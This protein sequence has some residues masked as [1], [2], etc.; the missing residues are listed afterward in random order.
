MTQDQRRI[1]AVALVP[2]FMSLLS[3]SIVNVVLPSIELSIGAGPSGLQWVLAGYTL[4]FGVMLVPAGR[5]GDLFGRARLFVLGVGLFGLAS[6]VAGLAPD[7]MVLN[8]ARL[9]MGFGSG[10]LN[11]QTVGFIQQ[12]FQGEQRGRAF[13]LF[14]SV[15]G[16]SVAIGPVLGGALIALL[17]PEWGWRSSFLINVPIAALAIGTAVRWLP[18]SAW[19][20]LPEAL[21]SGAHRKRPDLDP[22]GIVLLAAA[23]LAIMLPFL[24]A[25]AGSWIWALLPLGIV[26]LIAWLGWESRYKRSGRFPMVDLE[27]FRLRSFA[28]GSL[29]IGLYFTGMTSV[30][31]VIAIFLQ[32]GLG[33][34][35]LQAGFVGLP[36]AICSAVSAA[37]AGR[38]VV[39]VGRKLV[40]WGISVLLLGLAASVAVILLHEAIGSSIWWLLLTLS[41]VGLGQ[42]S[43]VSPNQTLTLRR[44]PMQYAGAAGGILQTGQR[45]GTAIGIAVITALFFSAQAAYGWTAAAVIA[46]TTIGLIIVLSGV[47]AAVDLV[48]ERRKRQ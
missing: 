7:V 40:L 21:E 29:L 44:V 6:L 14:G 20:A 33:Y 37:I 30:W 22:V 18:E 24:Q 43:V 16:I 8:I 35:A 13:G 4:A 23:T 39:G 32:T 15:V 9:F 38:Y 12:Y 46:F 11:P 19:Q 36:S 42:G 45:I 5:A 41:F 10:L 27:L 34:T 48:Q 2:L 26:L 25:S 17:G 3:V 28:N 47:V 31:V 1:L